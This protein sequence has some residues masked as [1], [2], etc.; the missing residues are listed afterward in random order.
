MCMQ[1]EEKI[2]KIWMCMQT[3]EKIPKISKIPSLH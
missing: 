1:T 2:S 3:E